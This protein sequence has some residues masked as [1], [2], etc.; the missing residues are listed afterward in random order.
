MMCFSTRK[1]TVAF[2]CENKILNKFK[3]KQK[4]YL[5]LRKNLLGSK[6]KAINIYFAKNIFVLFT[7]LICSYLYGFHVLVLVCR[8]F[9]LPGPVH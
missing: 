1:G 2:V 4:K 5:P 7:T 8:W 6:R 9:F 3:V